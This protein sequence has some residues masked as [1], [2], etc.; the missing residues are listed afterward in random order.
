MAE[1][2]TPY[3]SLKKLLS[4][5]NGFVAVSGIILVGLGIGGKCGGA[6]LTN[7]LG[8]SSAYLL[9]VGNLCLVM[10]CI[11]VLLGCAG[12]YGA[13]K[14]SRG[15][16]LFVGDVALE[17]TFV[18]LRKNYRGYNEPDDYSTQWNLVMEKLKCCGVNNYTD[19]S[20]SSFEMTTGHTYPRS[21]CK[22]IGSVSCDGRDVSPNV[23]H[24]K[25]CFHKLLKIT[26]TQS[27]TLS[28][29]SLGAAVI[30]LPGILATLLLFIKLG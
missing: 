21:C 10:G 7:V 12:W 17:H 11:T 15:T 20:G 3:S 29:S 24:Q 9:H 6:S 28:G 25:G 18:T 1:I 26:K 23:I 5:L 14:E 8:L 30:Q 16:L 4:L 27:F 19:F 22:S 2:H 13:T